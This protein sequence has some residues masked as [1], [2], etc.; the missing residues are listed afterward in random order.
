MRP[1]EIP[2]ARSELVGRRYSC[3]GLERRQKGTDGVGGQLL[4]GCFPSTSP[5]TEPGGRT[6]SR[7]SFQPVTFFFPPQR[8]YVYFYLCSLS[9]E[10]TGSLA[11][12]TLSEQ[13]EGLF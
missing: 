13:G 12:H 5:V 9:S 2:P 8:K 11:V 6:F 7:A 4:V 1:P 3:V 10:A